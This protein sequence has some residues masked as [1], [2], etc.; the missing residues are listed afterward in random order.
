MYWKYSTNSLTFLE[1]SRIPNART[2]AN[3]TTDTAHVVEVIVVDT[4]D[5]NSVQ[6]GFETFE[7]G[8]ILSNAIIFHVAPATGECTL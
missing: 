5:G 4:M 8:I 6:C 3:E 2:L 1:F 7:E